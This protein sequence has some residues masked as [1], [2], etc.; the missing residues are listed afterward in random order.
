MRLVLASIHVCERLSMHLYIFCISLQELCLFVYRTGSDNRCRSVN[1]SRL[2]SSPAVRPSDLLSEV[3]IAKS[4]R[5]ACM[6][7]T[8]CCYSL[9]VNGIYET[10]IYIVA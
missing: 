5:S 7:M 8:Q 4:D 9:V 2:R 6:L 3:R 10:N 1:G